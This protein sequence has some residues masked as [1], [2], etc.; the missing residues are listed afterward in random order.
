MLP[1]LI[2][3]ACMNCESLARRSDTQLLTDEPLSW[4]HYFNVTVCVKSIFHS[5]KVKYLHDERSLIM[6]II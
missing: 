2:N 6:D 4:Y 5:L 3:S 1:K